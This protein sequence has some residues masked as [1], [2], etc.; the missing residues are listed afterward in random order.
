MDLNGLLRGAETDAV[1]LSQ[2]DVSSFTEMVRGHTRPMDTS[3][4]SEADEASQQYV[5]ELL[6]MRLPSYLHPADVPACRGAP[7]AT[8]ADSVRSANEHVT[9][10]DAP[11]ASDKH[12]EKEDEDAEKVSWRMEGREDA[13]AA[14]HAAQ[15]DAWGMQAHE[16]SRGGEDMSWL[17]DG[18]N[19]G[20]ADRESDAL[21]PAQG[22][23][24]SNARP[25]AVPSVLHEASR[26]AQAGPS[27]TACR[28]Q[29]V[30]ALLQRRR[31]ACV[32]D[33]GCDE[34]QKEGAAGWF[35]DPAKGALLSFCQDGMPL[36]LAVV[37]NLCAARHCCVM[38]QRCSVVVE[39]E[40]EIEDL[41]G[42]NDESAPPMQAQPARRVP[43]LRR[44]T[45][46]QRVHVDPPTPAQSTGSAQ[47]G[48]HCSA[49]CTSMLS[50]C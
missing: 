2:D 39:D 22:H 25:A 20:T 44:Q 47:Q 13:H 15:K 30:P 18:M 31:Q 23:E 16:E 5:A 49:L 4:P 43:A 36:C 45:G 26:R 29:R 17:V 50:K 12:A 34:Q 3:Q 37:P 32:I 35:S 41:N 38:P 42:V 46:M 7:D 9:C 14:D 21:A 10:P 40:D 27:S 19:D 33:D 1:P 6:A 8:H 28:A 24:A 48:C 11:A